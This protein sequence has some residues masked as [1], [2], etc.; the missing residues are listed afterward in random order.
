MVIEIPQKNLK[1]SKSLR[2][3]FR[4]HH[5]QTMSDMQKKQFY[6]ALCILYM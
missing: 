5:Q 3:M 1:S 4:H 6:V 2:T